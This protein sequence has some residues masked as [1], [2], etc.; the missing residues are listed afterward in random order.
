MNDLLL[1]MKKIRRGLP[2]ERDIE[3]GRSSDR[4]IKP[5][6]YARSSSGTGLVLEIVCNRSMSSLVTNNSTVDVFST[7][8]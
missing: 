1:G 4:R 8:Y 7:N 5:I 6:V 3:A 2:S